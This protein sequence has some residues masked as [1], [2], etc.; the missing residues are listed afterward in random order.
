MRM[1][2]ELR[3]KPVLHLALPILVVGLA[4]VMSSVGQSAAP[5]AWPEP[6]VAPD[7]RLSSLGDHINIDGMPA[8]IYRFTTEAKPD[9]V[10]AYFR[11]HIDRDFARAPASAALEGQTVVAGRMGDYWVTLQLQ[12]QAG[13]SVG[14]WSAIP[15]FVPGVRQDARPPP[16]FPATAQLTRQIDSF[17]DGKRSQ[18]A[19]G[20]DPGPVDG[21]ALRL[22]DALKAQGFIKQTTPQAAWPRPAV[23]MATFRKDREEVLVTLEQEARGTAIMINRISALEELQ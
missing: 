14:T 18:M 13:Q 7:A 20:V 15:Q 3:V 5:G 2:P 4:G 19:V 8:R 1:K 23:Y 21:V 11:A 17:D 6:W 9:E 12:P 22:A 10:A 16:G